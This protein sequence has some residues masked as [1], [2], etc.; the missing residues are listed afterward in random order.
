MNAGDG[1]E[2]D[3]AGDGDAGE[4][5]L[6]EPAVVDPDEASARDMPVDSVVALPDIS[7]DVV[8]VCESEV[9]QGT[10]SDLQY[11]SGR[12]LPRSS[13]RYVLIHAFCL[14]ALAL[15]AGVGAQ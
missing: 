1:A 10:L 12:G 6:L 13:V 11:P 8:C 2:G 9:Y 3:E 7:G 14:P 15:V 5:E 4:L